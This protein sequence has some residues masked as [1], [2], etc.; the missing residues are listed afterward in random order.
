MQKGIQDQKT[1]V[2]ENH[3]ATETEDSYQRTSAKSDKSRQW[4]GFAVKKKKILIHLQLL[5]KQSNSDTHVAPALS[6]SPPHWCQVGHQL[7][8]YLV[9]CKEAAP[10]L[11]WPSVLEAAGLT[12]S[13]PCGPL[14]L[15]SPLESYLSY[16]MVISGRE[17]KSSLRS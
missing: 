13:Q 17:K 4:P 5:A 9:S 1:K 10:L 3:V 16:F 14:L 8:S 6:R 15:R 12:R 11:C 2:N 7:V